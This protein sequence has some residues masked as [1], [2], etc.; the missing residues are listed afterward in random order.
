MYD[1]IYN[2]RIVFIIWKKWRHAKQ[3]YTK[4]RSEIRSNRFKDKRSEILSIQY[5]S[6]YDTRQLPED[7]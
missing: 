5:S 2:E 6:H 7:D 3:H 4:Q 1:E